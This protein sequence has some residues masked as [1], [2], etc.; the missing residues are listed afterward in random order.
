MTDNDKPAYTTGILRDSRKNE[1]HARGCQLGSQRLHRLR[2]Q[3]IKAQRS[4]WRHGERRELE[5]RHNATG[6]LTVA[7]LTPRRVEIRCQQSEIGQE[8][9]DLLQATPKW[10]QWLKRWKTSFY[11]V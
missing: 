6:T 9:G 1:D 10:C 7:C 2:P 3:A 11:F 4:A 5:T 8:A